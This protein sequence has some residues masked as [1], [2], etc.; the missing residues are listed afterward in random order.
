MF[1]KV[2][3]INDNARRY[4]NFWNLLLTCKTEWKLESLV[5]R[6]D[7]EYNNKYKKTNALNDIPKIIQCYNYKK[8]HRDLQKPKICEKNCL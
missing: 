2:Y 3:I 8:V 6:K 7:I 4:A 5:K 1:L